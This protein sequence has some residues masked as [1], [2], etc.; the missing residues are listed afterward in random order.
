M[1]YPDTMTMN[2]DV[3][4]AADAASDSAVLEWG[5]RLGYAANGLVHLLIAWIAVRIAFGSGGGK[6]AD[7][8]G[9]LGTLARE[10]FGQVLLWVAVVGFGLL[11][12]WQITELITRHEAA[13]RIKAAGKA[14]AYAALGWT[15]LTF[16]SGGN[17]NSN[18][19]TKDFTAT[20]ME[21]PGGQ[22]LVGAVGLGIVG[23]GGYHVYK[24]WA[25]KFLEDL[26]E[27][28]GTFAEIAGRVGYIAKGV[29]LGI[30]GVLFLVAAVKHQ[31]GKASGL[32]GAL[33][34]LRDAPYGQV[35]L[36]AAAVGIAAFGVYC[37]ARARYARV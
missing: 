9:A 24:G 8:S 20:L 5:A 36:A 16:A 13:D 15:A 10:S 28:P 33:R 30:V 3:R 27:H 25:Q 17:S 23:V 31:S 6:S 21:Q 35:L 14:V 12:I 11:A 26:R 1:G 32:D 34:T 19:Q 22:L 7:Q 4:G 2:P 29:A 18:K 37:F